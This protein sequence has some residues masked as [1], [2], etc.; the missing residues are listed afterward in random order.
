MAGAL[1]WLHKRKEE[2]W[3]CW[4]TGEEGRKLIGV[5]QVATRL[6]AI[7]VV[8]AT[9]G[10]CRVATVVV[11]DPSQN[12]GSQIMELTMIGMWNQEE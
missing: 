2:D 7:A 11:N 8:T 3:F 12:Q 6:F 9:V 4:V 10:C 5:S 1:H